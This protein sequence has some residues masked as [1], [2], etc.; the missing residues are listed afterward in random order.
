MKM[1]KII[2]S[3]IVLTVM[4]TG[5]AQQEE[6]QKIKKTINTFSEA[7][8]NN[9][10]EQLAKVLDDNYRIVMNRLFGSTE[11]SVMT[12]LVYLDKIK[13]KEFGGDKREL[14][15]DDVLVNGNTASAKVL[16]KGQKM[17]STSLII[18]LQDRAG[19]W[20]LVSD[21]PVIKS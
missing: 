9:D 20:K 8:D 14:K 15:I 3:V 2:M 6:I 4:T 11:V 1:K 13:S 17:T 10:S 7:G 19:V 12:R 5:L 18:L 21:V 16:F